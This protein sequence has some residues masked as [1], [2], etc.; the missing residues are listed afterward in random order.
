MMEI[1]AII[2]FPKNLDIIANLSVLKDAWHVNLM[3]NAL[4]ADLDILD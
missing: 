4:C 3:E 1:I 2:A